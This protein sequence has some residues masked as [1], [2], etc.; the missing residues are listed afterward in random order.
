MNN[1]QSVEQ[2]HKFKMRQICLEQLLNQILVI[3]WTL[4]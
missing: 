2:F 4:Q 1:R 3:I